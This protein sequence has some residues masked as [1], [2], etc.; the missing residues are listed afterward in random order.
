[1]S[2]AGAWTAEFQPESRGISAI[3][4]L[5]VTQE[6]GDGYVVGDPMC[7]E[8]CCTVYSIAIEEGS[9]WEW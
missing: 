2:D 3:S 6:K 7:N 4:T 9:G 5:A 8:I 1:M